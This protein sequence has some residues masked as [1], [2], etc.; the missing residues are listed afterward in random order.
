ML[1]PHWMFDS[2][3]LPSFQVSVDV[4]DEYVMKAEQVKII[5]DIQHPNR[6]KMTE[7]IMIEAK[8][9]LIDI[10]PHSLNSLFVYTLDPRHEVHELT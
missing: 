3:N 2:C 10:P 6:L 4:G 9:T 1:G 7:E 5:V 8:Y